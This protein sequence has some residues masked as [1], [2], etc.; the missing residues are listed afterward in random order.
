MRLERLIFFGV[1][2][3]AC[4]GNHI[5]LPL[6]LPLLAGLYRFYLLPGS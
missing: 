6:L 5:G 2:G 4:R 3:L 1:A